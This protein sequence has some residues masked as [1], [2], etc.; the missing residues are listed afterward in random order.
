MSNTREDTVCGMTLAVT[1]CYSYITR[2]SDL[3]HGCNLSPPCNIDNL[4]DIVMDASHR[5]QS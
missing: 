3:L 4:H 2:F 5:G 1:E